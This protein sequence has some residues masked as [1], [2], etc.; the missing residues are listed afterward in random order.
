MTRQ[1]KSKAL[2]E[3]VQSVFGEE[4]CTSDTTPQN[5]GRKRNRAHDFL[6]KRGRSVFNRADRGGFGALPGSLSQEF[7]R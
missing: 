1:E 5:I 2:M 3:M 6:R 7:K 4:N